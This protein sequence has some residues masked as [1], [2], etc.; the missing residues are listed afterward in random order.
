MLLYNSTMRWDKELILSS[1]NFYNYSRSYCP[2][3]NSLNASFEGY[4]AFSAP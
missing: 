1:A 3:A 4:L 2:I